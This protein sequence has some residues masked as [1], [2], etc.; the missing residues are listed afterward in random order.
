MNAT[1]QC[2][3]NTTLLTDY[4][5]ET[6]KYDPEEEDKIISNEYYNLIK[7][8]WNKE[9]DKKSYSPNSF[10]EVLEKENPLLKGEAENEPKE[11]IKFLF[12]RFHQELN[13][14]KQ[15]EIKLR[16]KN[17]NPTDNQLN[18]KE[19]LNNFLT[20]FKEQYD[21]IISNLFYGVRKMKNICQ[22][23]NTIK[24]NFN[25][26]SYLEF[27]LEEIKKYC[28]DKGIETNNGINIY[29]CFNYYVNNKKMTGDNQIY[30]EKCQKYC[31]S[32][33][34]TS[35]YSAPNYLVIILNRGK[36]VIN[37]CNVKF[38]AKLNILNYVSFKDGNTYYELYA[39]ICQ[40]GSSSMT[41]HFVA[42]IKNKINKKWY[43]YNDSI[44]TPCD[45]KDE[46]KN[47]MS[48]AL[49]YKAL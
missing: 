34:R 48:Y 20:E 15:K 38:P 40:S 41:R 26:F 25:V 31:D 29:E 10:K 35:L 7:N 1:L 5:L 11:L 16:F 12:E 19:I 36:G 33:Y 24:Y 18:E 42:Y 13:M 39:V 22:S 47:E 43:K 14:I 30:C 23:C 32:L 37:E 4:F 46:Y 49:F 8:L 27:P 2:L 21:S 9:N 45:K 28:F 17:I 6:Y 3:S 44:V